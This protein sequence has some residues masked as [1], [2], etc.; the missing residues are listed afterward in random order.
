MSLG[1]RVNPPPRRQRMPGGR[2]LAQVPDGR[3][4]R[5]VQHVAQAPLPQGRPEGGG[6]PEL[7]V[8]GHPSKRHVRPRALQQVQANA[9]AFL[10]RH[11]FRDVR[12]LPASRV[13]GPRVGQVQAPIQR[14]VA[15]GRDVG[16]EHA[17]LAVL[18]LAQP[19]APLPGHA[20]GGVA[21]LGKAAAV[22]DQYRVGVGPRL[23]HVPTQLRHNRLVVP[24]R[25][26]ARSAAPA[27]VRGWP[28]RRW[29]PKSCVGDCS[30]CPG[31]SPEPTPAGYRVAAATPPPPSPPAIPAASSGT[32]ACRRR[33][34]CTPSTTRQ[35]ALAVAAARVAEHQPRRHA[36]FA[37]RHHR[38]AHPV[39]GRR[40]RQQ[41][42]HMVDGAVGRRHRR[43]LAARLDD[44]RP[45]RSAPAARTCSPASCDR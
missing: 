9:R 5:H 11:L 18:D 1:P 23:G 17:H 35:V 31:E 6:P 15:L 22:H 45:A 42:F 13:F 29:V 43:T 39:A 8:T 20:A 21:L 28:G 30:A 4:G 33:R 24:G 32:S 2:R 41:T 7:V 40:R 38:R 37:L 14:G 44:R 26:R 27:C 36:V 19:P 12:L 3:G 34:A 16:Q 10:E 25:R